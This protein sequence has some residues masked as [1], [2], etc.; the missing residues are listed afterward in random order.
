MKTI[1]LQINTNEHR[2]PVIIGSGLVK[3]LSN[4]IWSN[5]KA[6]LYFFFNSSILFIQSPKYLKLSFFIL[7]LL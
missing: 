3:K 6:L 2:Y 1:K 4:L 7:I 5:G